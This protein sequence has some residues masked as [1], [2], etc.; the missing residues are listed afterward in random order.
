M[1]PSHVKVVVFGSFHAGKSTFIQAIDPASRHV[2]AEG[3]EGSTTVAIDFGRVEVLGR[4]VHLFGTPGQERFEFIREFTENGMDAAILMIDCSCPVDG[5]TRDLYTHLRG[6]GVPVGIM[7]NKCDLGTS[8]P[9][10]AREKFLQARTFELS[11]LDPE[12]ARKALE[13]FL[14]VV[15][16]EKN[17]A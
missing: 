3:K 5:F 8:K 10:I 16:S 15:I 17:G 1:N 11:S 9:Q 13:D 4:Q 6:T 2:Q 12:S 7:L 14:E